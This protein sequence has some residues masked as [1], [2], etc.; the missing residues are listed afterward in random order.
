[1]GTQS[2]LSKTESTCSSITSNDCPSI[3]VHLFTLDFLIIPSVP[4]SLPPNMVLLL[5][6]FH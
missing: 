1:M 5:D 6:A 4:F 3:Y 2:Q